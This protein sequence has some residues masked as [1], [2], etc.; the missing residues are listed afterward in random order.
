MKEPPSLLLVRLG[1]LGDVVLTFAAA[2]SLRRARP[3][4][5]LVYLVK[6]CYAP[7]VRTQPWVDEVVA[8][9][10]GEGRLARALRL[11]RRLRRRRWAGVLDWQD[12]LESRLLT[13]GLG[14]RAS[15]WDAARWARRRI[16][17][18]RRWPAWIQSYGVRPAWRRCLDVARP[19]GAAGEDPPR[20]R[21]SGEAESVAA[22]AWRRWGAGEEPVVALAPGA[23]WPTKT[24]P[25]ARYLAVGRQLTGLGWRVLVV[26]TAA[27]KRSL[28]DLD[29]W[30]EREPRA[31][32]FTSH[33]PVIA[34]L[35]SRCR[36][37]LTGDTGLLHLSA[38]V[39][40]PAVA[41]YGSTSPELGLAPVGPGHVVLCLDLPCQPCA[42]HGRRRCPLGHLACL[43]GLT[44]GRVLE[45]LEPLG[46]RLPAPASPAREVP[47]LEGAS[48]V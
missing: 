5:R 21:W 13:W 18:S 8:L 25:E 48:R 28:R 12:S 22:D 37:T 14:V 38:A 15:R 35:L 20:V 36:A 2:E 42:L 19:F 40:T 4:A 29:A 26:S 24:W 16:V 9:Q 7:L 46:A 41:L 47:S 3:E 23:A 32:W 43:H 10:E 34:A 17:W 1:S 45:V 30:V 27:E 6:E 31:L 44:P 11:R 33:L 39:G